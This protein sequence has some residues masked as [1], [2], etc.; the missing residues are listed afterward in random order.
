[1]NQKIMTMAP[2]QAK[3]IKNIG[4]RL[5]GRT[6]RRGVFAGGALLVAA[7]LAAI[8]A[9][10]TPGGAALIAAMTAIGFLT[11]SGLWLPFCFARPA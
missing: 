4:W 6:R 5:A 1:L 11:S 9:F 3:G 10:T 7:A 8:V 2:K